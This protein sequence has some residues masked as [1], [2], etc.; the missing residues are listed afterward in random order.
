[1]GLAVCW[2]M[3]DFMWVRQENSPFRSTSIGTDNNTAFPTLEMVPDPSQCAGLGIQI[4]HGNV[5][6]AL[7]LRGMEVHGDDMVAPGR[8]QH[9]GNELGRYRS[10]ALVFLILARIGEVRDDS[11]DAAG[12]GGLAG[13]DHDEKFHEPV[14]DVARGSRLQDEHCMN[15]LVMQDNTGGRR[16]QTIFIS[17][18]LPNSNACLLIRIVQT[19]GLG[20]FDAETARRNPLA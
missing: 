3:L 5:E 11:S 16:K 19:H 10:S 2:G 14:V 6:E 9:I 20:Q 7:D 4:V 15:R 8:L 13:V 17:N 12:A 1:M 18:T